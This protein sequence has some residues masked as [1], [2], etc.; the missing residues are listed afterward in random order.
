MQRIESGQDLLALA[1]PAQSAHPTAPRYLCMTASVADV[2]STEAFGETNLDTGADAGTSAEVHPYL[3]PI[4]NPP[5]TGEDALAAAA[6]QTATVDCDVRKVRNTPA[7]VQS[8]RA[9]LAVTAPWLRR[10]RCPACLVGFIHH[11]C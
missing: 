2:P 11:A 3:H 10:G 8:L 6:H 9:L 4:S 7:Y 1:A 5:P